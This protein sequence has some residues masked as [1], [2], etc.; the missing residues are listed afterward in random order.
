[1]AGECS[2]E[3]ENIYT[4]AQR[5]ILS[6]REKKKFDKIRGKRPAE[7]QNCVDKEFLGSDV[8]HTVKNKF[9]HWDHANATNTCKQVCAFIDYY[10]FNP[11]PN[12]KF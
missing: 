5:R 11:F 6:L 3:S 1:M 12:E 2:F 10:Y 8:V 4:H 9:L 7:F